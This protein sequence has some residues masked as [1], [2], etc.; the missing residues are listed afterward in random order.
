MRKKEETSTTFHILLLLLSIGATI[1]YLADTLKNR[2][3]SSATRAAME[4]ALKD[5]NMCIRLAHA[6]FTQE[7]LQRETEKL[8]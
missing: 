6:T 4:Q 5:N 1:I 7:T 3:V 8:R 2:Y